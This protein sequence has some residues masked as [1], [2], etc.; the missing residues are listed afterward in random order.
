MKAPNF[1]ITPIGGV[2][3][4]GS[5]M[6][7]VESKGKRLVIDC[8]IL[9]PYEDFFDINYLIP[10]MSALGDIDA[11]IITHG[12]EDHIGA[13]PHIVEKYPS[14]KIYAPAL[15]A[16]LIQHKLSRAN[17]QTKINIYR[18]S[19]LLAFGDLEVHPVHVNHSIPQTFG[20]VLKDSNLSMSVFFV[21][22]FKVDFST[23]Y[24]SPFDFQKL[25]KITSDTK[26]KLLLSD[27]TNITSS[28]EKTK[29]EKDVLEGLS[30]I[31]E[32]T[33][34]IFV[35]SFSS[36]IHRLQSFINLATKN[37]RPIVLYGAAMLKYSQI[38][39][40]LGLLED[41]HN[42]IKEANS[43]SPNN[44]NL[45]VVCSGSQGEFRGTLRRIVLKEDPIFKPKPEDRFVFSSKAIPG[46]EKKLSLLFNQISELG[47]RLHTDQTD[48]IHASGHPGKEDLLMLMKEFLPTHQ[49]PIHGESLFLEKHE[50]FINEHF[51]KTKTFR[52]YNFQSL[53]LTQDGGFE[54]KS[55]QVLP[56]ILIH[57]RGIPIERKKISERRKLACNGAIFISVSNSKRNASID[58]TYNGIA[59][60]FLQKSEE[61]KSLLLDLYQ[62]SRSK[63]ESKRA[64][65]LRVFTRRYFG[66]LFG[67]KPMTFVH[68]HE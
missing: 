36:N 32:K 7:L 57:A 3:Q 63:D 13:V 21:S 47:A 15:A 1:R 28:N 40:D 55:E 17:L 59:D 19:D 34:R 31:F 49:A 10:D 68:L 42:T 58:I 30:P 6:T 45:V 26:T 62:N 41:P 65:E 8:G 44:E 33:G 53:E 50:K 51:S 4:I 54:H 22:D 37:K 66:E 9:F 46:N 18:E 56:P 12:H 48:P 60:T 39:L 11:L 20:L 5:N 27:S 52:L 2:A 67:L 23:P 35:T 14:L 29:S 64:E 61:F 43:V 24:E 16:E 25:K 38:A